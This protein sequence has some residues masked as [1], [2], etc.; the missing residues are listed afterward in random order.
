MSE[1]NIQSN[2]FAFVSLVEYCHE[3]LTEGKK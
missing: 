2:A 1:S 3:T